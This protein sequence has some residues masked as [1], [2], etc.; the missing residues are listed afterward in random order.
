MWQGQNN[1]QQEAALCEMGGGGT[2]LGQELAKRVGW[3]VPLSKSF[4]CRV[5]GFDMSHLPRV[6]AKGHPWVPLSLVIHSLNK[7]KPD[8]AAPCQVLVQVLGTQS[9]AKT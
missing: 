7:Y 1:A 2:L 3:G 5:T 8:T 4:L 9:L 6:P